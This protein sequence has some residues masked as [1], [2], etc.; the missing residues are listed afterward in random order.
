MNSSFA[1]RLEKVEKALGVQIPTDLQVFLSTY[2]H[3]DEEVYE[4]EFGGDVSEL[5]TT[6]RLDGGPN[7]P[8]LDGLLERVGHAIPRLAVPIAADWSGNFFLFVIRGEYEGQMV[9]WDHE[10]NIGDDS[11]ISTGLTLAQFLSQMKKAE[12]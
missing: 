10:R 8:Q 5:R 3:F 9:F 12:K 6:Y 7:Y 2:S 4:I 1:L 11:V